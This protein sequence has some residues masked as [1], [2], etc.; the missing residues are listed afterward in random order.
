MIF[1]KTNFKFYTSKSNYY[2]KYKKFIKT[3][4]KDCYFMKLENAPKT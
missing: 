4:K 2:M 3:T 1:I